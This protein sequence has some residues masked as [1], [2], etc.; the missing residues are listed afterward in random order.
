MDEKEKYLKKLIIYGDLMNSAI[1]SLLIPLVGLIIYGV[2]SYIFRETTGEDYFTSLQYTILIML[3]IIISGILG[4][5]CAIQFG[6]KR[7][8]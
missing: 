1:F 3:P 6:I 8:K 4:V 2:I 5:Y 7:K